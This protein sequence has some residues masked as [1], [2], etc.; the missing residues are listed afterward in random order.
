MHSEQRVYEEYLDG[1]W[2]NYKQ[3]H[4]MEYPKQ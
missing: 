1:M 3:K 2:K 4:A